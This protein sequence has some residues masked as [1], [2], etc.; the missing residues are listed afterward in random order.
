MVAIKSAGVPGLIYTPGLTS[1]NVSSVDMTFEPS[2]GIMARRVNKLGL[3]IRSFREPLQRA[4]R[5]V[6]IP[7]IEMNF[8]KHGRPRWEPLSEDTILNR[9][10]NGFDLNILTR[11][12]ALRKGATQMKIWTIDREKAFIANLPKNIWYGVVHQAGS[13]GAKKTLT[14]SG[15]QGFGSMTKTLSITESHGDIPARPF[16]LLQKSEEELLDEVFLDWLDE[17][18]LAAGLKTTARAKILSGDL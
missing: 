14:G 5:E 17:R 15:R 7:S 1:A 2:L 16:V 3:D 6:V 12:G 13:A 18:A 9:L 8:R 4:V 10:G 11:T